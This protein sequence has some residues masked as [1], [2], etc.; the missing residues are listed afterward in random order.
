MR[1]P[2]RIRVLC[3]DDS[4]RLTEAWARFFRMQSDIELVGTLPSADELLETLER[5][6]P[7]VVLMDLTMDGRDPLDAIASATRRHPEV[8]IIVCTG[9][10]DAEELCR[11]VDAGAW[12][13][14]NKGHGPAEILDAVRRVARGQM[15]SQSP[16]SQV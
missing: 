6:R 16:D 12:G 8:R 1:D 10:T 14:I 5:L 4:T 7:Q 2:D 11:A 9:R 15:P 3:V 13:C